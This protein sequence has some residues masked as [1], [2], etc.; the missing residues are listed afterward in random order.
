MRRGTVDRR[1]VALV[2][3]TLGAIAALAVL[4][5]GALPGWFESLQEDLGYTDGELH[6]VEQ[7]CESRL[8]RISDG[9]R[10]DAAYERCE[11]REK[12]RINP[13]PFG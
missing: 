6:R 1:D 3:A 4:V 5:I 7:T 8:E 2:I 13:D 9:D 10:Y 11:E 12:V